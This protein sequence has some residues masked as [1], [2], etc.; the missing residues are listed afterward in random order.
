MRK[1][2][3]VL[4]PVAGKG[5]G[6]KSKEFIVEEFNKSDIEF[7]IVESSYEGEI[8]II[9]SKVDTDK[10]TEIILVGGDGTLVEAINGLKGK[11]IMLGIIPVG[12]G[13]DFAR[14]LD[15]KITIE[16]SIEIIINGEYVVSDI[17]LV[18]DKYFVNVTGFGIV[19]DILV[20]MVKIKKF[21]GGSL[22]YLASTIYT[23]FSYKSKIAKIHINNEVFERDIMLAVVSNGKYFGGGMKISPDA[24]IDDGEF[25]LVIVNKLSIPKF[26]WLFKR[27]YNGTHIEVK[28]VEVFKSNSFYIESDEKFVINVDGNLYGSTPVNIR[29][30]N[31]K[32]KIF[33]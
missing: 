2:L 7:D 12:S 13:N 30:V 18:N 4:N 21:F 24:K 28:E 29:M 32:F 22:A 9:A 17:G 1:A 23:L 8:E 6:L 19:S 3:I 27:V 5:N 25:E 20:N 14:N 16:K 26:L 11:D 10:Y 33:C 31:E 15:E